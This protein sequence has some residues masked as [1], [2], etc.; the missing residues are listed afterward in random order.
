[1]R[2]VAYIRRFAAG[3]ALAAASSITMSPATNAASSS[4]TF[5]YDALG[6]VST[7][8]Y[9]TGI[10]VTYTYDANGNRL[11]QSI[12]AGGPGVNWGGFNW[13]AA[14]WGGTAATWGISKWGAALW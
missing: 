8:T 13:S 6:R 9:D 14:S 7:A 3:S 1:M 4:V 2:L 12:T 5:T 11:V 10:I